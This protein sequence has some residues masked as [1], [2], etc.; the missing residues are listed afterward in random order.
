VA[1]TFFF[2]DIAVLNLIATHVV[3]T[4][5]GYSKVGIWDA[6]C[7]MGPEPYS[8]A[9]TLAER[10]GNFAFRNIHIDATDIEEQENCGNTIETGV[11]PA[12]QLKSVP[13]EM[14]SK[15]FTPAGEEGHFR[16][17]DRIRQS[18]H[19]RRHD[20]LSLKPPADGYRLI[21]CKNVLLHFTPDQRIKVIRMFHSVLAYGGFFA[22]EQTQ[23][24]PK[25]LAPLFVQV[26]NEGSLYMKA[27]ST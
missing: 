8:L 18:I 26:S 9:I 1:F 19:Y 15:Y 3:P 27:V 24:M 23:E 17:I 10:M 4:L 2:R 11:Y 7:A 6:G 14:F 13:P 12:E 5:S 21:V 16:I 20:L 25:E 22:T